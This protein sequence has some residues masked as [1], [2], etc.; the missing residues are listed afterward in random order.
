MA[1]GVRP[2]LIGEDGGSAA[3]APPNVGEGRRRHDTG[4]PLL[5]AERALDPAEPDGALLPILLAPVPGDRRRDIEQAPAKP[6]PPC[7]DLRARR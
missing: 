7:A 2:E 1:A 6:V 3:L 4:S 5:A